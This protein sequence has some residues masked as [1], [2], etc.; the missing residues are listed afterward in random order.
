MIKRII[1]INN[2]TKILINFVTIIFFKL[3]DKFNLLNKRDFMFVS[4]RVEQLN[5][6]NNIMLYIVNVYIVIVQIR[7]V[8][9]KKILFKNIK[10]K[11]VQKYKKKCYLTIVENVYLTTNFKNYKFAFRN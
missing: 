7:N 2:V 10:L 5:I 1:K 4:Q 11:I 3:R 9:S 8:N 6:E